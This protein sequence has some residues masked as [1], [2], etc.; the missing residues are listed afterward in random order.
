MK[1]AIKCTE[2]VHVLDTEQVYSIVALAAFQSKKLLAIM[3]D[4]SFSVFTIFIV[5]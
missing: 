3:Y 4:T 1:T 5:N 2:F